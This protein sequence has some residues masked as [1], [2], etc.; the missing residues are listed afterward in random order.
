MQSL[1]DI[2]FGGGGEATYD[3]SLSADEEQQFQKWKAQY[4]PKDSGA[5]YD[6][7]GA[8]KAGLTPDAK[9]GHWP[10]TYKKPNHPTFSNESKYA[11]DR[12]D[13]AGH[14]EGEKYVPPGKRPLD[15][16]LFGSDSAPATPK[17]A[18]EEAARKFV[19]APHNSP[20]KQ[21]ALDEMYAATKAA[22]RA[23]S[24]AEAG[25]DIPLLGRV[26]LPQAGAMAAPTLAAAATGGGS[27]PANAGLAA[28]GAAL[29]TEL[30]EKLRLAAGLPEPSIADVAKRTGI[31]A[32]T[33]AALQTIG[34]GAAKTVLSPI[35]NPA[36]R[37]IAAE[38]ERLGIPASPD[39]LIAAG[40]NPLRWA[41]SMLRGVGEDV[42]TLGGRLGTRAQEGVS[43]ATRDSV[44]A[45]VDRLGGGLPAPLENPSVAGTVMQ[46]G[47][48]SLSEAGKQVVRPIY[49]AAE[50]AAQADPRAV[51]PP[52]NL[53]RVYQSWRDIKGR[54]ANLQP[55][56]QT[57]LNKIRDKIFTTQQ[58]LPPYQAGGGLTGPPQT[59]TR[60]TPLHYMDMA[61]L[62]TELGQAAFKTAEGGVAPPNEA[63]LRQL[64]HA[65]DQD[66]GTIP[67][68]QVVHLDRMARDAYTQFEVP[69][70]KGEG[71]D[72]AALVQG[73]AEDYFHKLTSPNGAQLIREIGEVNALHPNGLGNQ[74]LA[75]VASEIHHKITQAAMSEVPGYGRAINGRL[76]RKGIDQYAASLE[77][78]HGPG[79]VDMARDLA[80]GIERAQ[81]VPK[82]AFGRLLLEGGT[83]LHAAPSYGAAGLAVAAVKTLPIA[84]G[85]LAISRAMETPLGMRW[86]AQGFF[87]QSFRAAAGVIANAGYNRLMKPPL[88][89]AERQKVEATL[90]PVTQAQ[91]AA[92]KQGPQGEVPIARI[93]KE[94]SPYDALI[95][96]SATANGLSPQLYKA[97]I[98]QESAFDPKA[99][100]PKG[101]K[102]LPQLMPET[103]KALGVND[104]YDPTQSVPAGAK[105]LSDLMQ[106]YGG[107]KAKALAAYN[108][109]PAAVDKYGGVPPFEE[110]QKYVQA[111]LKRE[112]E[113]SSERQAIMDKTE[114]LSWPDIA[115]RFQQA[116][117]NPE[118]WSSLRRAVNA[119]IKNNLNK[120]TLGMAQ[121]D[122]QRYLP[123]IVEALKPEA[124]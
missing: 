6:L 34:E 17:T 18:A 9:T 31:E 20:E 61:Q 112:Q 58:V 10:D 107:D 93:S 22:D 103:A 1:D 43:H 80:G 7:R 98:A 119:R 23:K 35:A 71:R 100:S 91:V 59:V 49:Q 105:L 28:A 46:Q 68:A 57:V 78:L 60:L 42:R 81:Q 26:S 48:E 65:I 19:A 90:P 73:S 116:K 115:K 15:D 24:V 4:A 14:W 27:I 72:L 77:Q 83:L 76:L 101:A 94:D 38:G 114:N 2:L 3:T 69:F 97:V 56:D 102:G 95:A 106:R 79:Y 113:Y 12:P 11:K 37:A 32:G 89:D 108:S 124:T 62:R 16:I 25:V 41:L 47:V 74:A 96:S 123:I 29:G 120:P 64:R 39:R 36:T 21:A 111:V 53:M 40:S 110:T 30:D 52:S 75:Q 13:L 45:A 87:P 63:M 117:R 67:N 33:Q 82:G 118:Q 88:T 86:L 109:R 122:Y 66:V 70:R 99:T 85:T 104:P 8:F 55:Q 121:A 84:L 50:A 92:T 44:Q 5:D 54:G 51:A